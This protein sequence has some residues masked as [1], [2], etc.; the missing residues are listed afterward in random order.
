MNRVLENRIARL[1]GGQPRGIEA[2]TDAELESA[3][4]WLT[5]NLGGADTAREHVPP[6][7]LAIFDEMASDNE[8][9]SRQS[10]AEA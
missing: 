7:L 3:V 6:H 1:E 9:Q 5:E 10:I 8:P 2:L 4:R